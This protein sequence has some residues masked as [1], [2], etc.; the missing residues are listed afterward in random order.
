[1]KHAFYAS[2]QVSYLV[3]KLV[4][5]TTDD[6]L[7]SFCMVL[8]MHE[9]LWKFTVKFCCRQS[10]AV[11]CEMVDY[12]KKA[13]FIT[14]IR[15]KLHQIHF[16]NRNLFYLHS[17]HSHSVAISSTQSNYY[18]RSLKSRIDF[19][20]AHTNAVLPKSEK[21]HLRCISSSNVGSIEIDP[22]IKHSDVTKIHEKMLLRML[23]NEEKKS[24]HLV[25]YAKNFDTML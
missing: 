12:H 8:Q 13:N 17:F 16:Q 11:G 5:K 21:G 18:C 7:Q 9:M 6:S 23:R 14:K 22:K 24:D 20:Y 15:R 3:P 1:M 19:L 10:M 2:C 25:E 4:S